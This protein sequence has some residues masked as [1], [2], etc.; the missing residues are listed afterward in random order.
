[1]PLDPQIEAL[2]RQGQEA[3]AKPYHQLTVEEARRSFTAGSLALA[4]PAEEVARVEDLAVP[5]ADG[6]PE[7]PVRL[8][9]PTGEAPLPLVV[10]LHGGG[11]VVGTLEGY[12]AVCRALA[13]A[14]GAVVASVDYR[15]APEHRFPAAVED[16]WA[17]TR[18]LH[19]HAADLGADPDRMA[20]GGDSAGANL[21]TVV[22]RRA[23][24]HRA[25]VLRAQLLIYPAL[26]PS[27]E[28]PSMTELA[29]GHYLEREDMRWFWDHYLGPDGDPGELE[30]SPGRA[31]DLAGLAPAVVLT[32]EYDPLRDEGE[33]YAARLADAGVPVVATRYLGMIHAFADPVRFDAAH[34][35]IDEVAGALRRAAAVPLTG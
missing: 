9:T 7:I 32:A 18:W 30:A 23:R 16:A 20:V 26:D 28:T 15:L 25:P 35:V 8:Y 31:D 4:G 11:W 24:D 33:A 10:F 22:A 13:N 12:D 29:T 14:A 27:L 17:A 21:A 2:I 19:D 1:M 34:A 3:G 6:G 5:G